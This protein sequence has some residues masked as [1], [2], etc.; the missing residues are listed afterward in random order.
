MIQIPTLLRLLSA[1]LLNNKLV[2]LELLCGTL[3]NA[4]LD[5]VLRDEAEDVDLLGLT[6]TVRTIHGLQVCL[7]VP[8]AVK[9][10]NNVGSDK[11]DTKTTSTGREQEDKLVA[12][13]G[14]VVVNGRNTVVVG[15]ITVDA[16]VL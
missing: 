9:Q 1:T 15:G 10:D 7:R 6:D 8:V 14:V 3:K 11:V 16:A 12:V 2:K 4:L 13:R 5:C